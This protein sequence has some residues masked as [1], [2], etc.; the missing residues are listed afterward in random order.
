MPAGWIAFRSRC[1]R[2]V[3]GPGA[4]I[5][6]VSGPTL[7]PEERDFLREAAPWGFILFARN[8]ATPDQLRRLTGDLRA[9]VG[10]EAPI[11]VDQEGGR[12]ARLGPPH[13]R[14]WPPARAET[15]HAGARAA[16]TMWLRYR[17]IAAEL[18]AVGIDGNCAPVADIAT[19]DTHA[20]LAD[21]CYGDS[22]PAVAAAARAVAEGL[23]AGG[24]L[25]VL[26][27][28]PGHGRGVADSH[29][30]LPVVAAP[31]ADLR[32][33]DFAA[34]AQLADLPLA[35]TAHIAYSALDPDRPATV[36]PDAIAAIRGEMGFR[37][38]LMTDDISMQALDGPVGDRAAAALRAGCDVVLHCNGEPCE[39]Q[40]VVA[41]A[42][43]LDGA[44]ADRA[45]AA[46]AA[47]RVPAP[48]DLDAL[49]REYDGIAGNG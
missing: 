25:P 7:L 26:K 35:M 24:V 17:L 31:L 19:D 28:I 37:G 48:A 33:R 23:L 5:L 47:R 4:T 44:A 21:R 8:V 18:R 40:A 29:H 2:R 22:L 42:G 36:S 9:A 6:G 38:L 16:R 46:L 39:M 45:A 34:F 14:T 12:V 13:W 3:A 43:S 1:G 41:A 49:A 20:V 10:R 11:F 32:G 27:H 15:A 30:D